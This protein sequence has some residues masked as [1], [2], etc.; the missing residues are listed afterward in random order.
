MRIQLNGDPHET[1]ATTVAD[2][3]SEITD[4]PDGVAVAVGGQ[5]VPRSRWDTPLADGD[6]V[7]V[8]TAV[9]GG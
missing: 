4:T 8:L 6:T 1:A 5:M 7:D 3:V 9:Q 2:L